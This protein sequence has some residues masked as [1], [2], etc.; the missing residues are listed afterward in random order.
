[1]TNQEQVI[2]ARLAILTMAA[3]LK[4]VAKVCRIAGVSRSQFYAMKKLYEIHGKAGLA[5]RAR[6]RPVMPNRTPPLLEEQILLNTRRNPTLSYIRLSG[7]M[8][9]DGIGVSPAMVRYVWQRH[10][11]S[12]RSARLEWTK[13]FNGAA[14]QKPSDDPYE[15]RSVQQLSP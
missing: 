1:M 9:S 2:R 3:E 8:E 12:T 11:L 6:R 7:E 4:N 10:G 15:L 5:P 13:G 14:S